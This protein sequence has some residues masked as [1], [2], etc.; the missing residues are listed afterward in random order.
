MDFSIVELLLA[1]AAGIFGAA[2]GALPVWI[3]CGLAV[4]IGTVINMS[5]GQSDIINL[6]AWGTF[7]G[8]HTSFAGGVAA[9]AYAARQNDLDNGRDIVTA[10]IGLDKP[11]IL[12]VGGLYGMIGY[13]LLW[14]LSLVPNYSELAWTN[15]IALAVI[16]NMFIARLF[17]GNT[18][19]LG[20]TSGVKNRWIPTDSGAWVPYQSKPLMLLLLGFAV[21]LPAAYFAEVMPGSVGLTFGIVTF[22]LI[23]M[24]FGYKVPV[25]HH[26]ALSASMLTAATGNM[27]W[28][29]G[30]GILAAFLGEISACLF[31]YHGDTHI[32][33]PTMALVGTFTIYPLLDYA[34]IFNLNANLVWLIIAMIAFL[35]WLLLS[36]LKNEGNLKEKLALKV[37]G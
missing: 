11:K 20:N 24:Q 6:L 15:T 14:M 13:V 5:T 34:G 17:L 37:G 4:L 32:D 8:P 2:I 7:L 23:F 9:A 10:L 19:L 18:G 16:L 33:P 30:F 3:L 28:G 12:V 35:G 21:G 1:F 22:L 27:V 26:I 25:T 36:A 29:V 31:T